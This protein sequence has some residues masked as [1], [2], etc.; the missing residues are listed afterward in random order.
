MKE[1]SISL[2]TFRRRSQKILFSD[3]SEKFNKSKSM[4]KFN[5]S[6]LE[7]RIQ[8]KLKGIRLVSEK[9]KDQQEYDL[10]LPLIKT[11]VKE[12]INKLLSPPKKEINRFTMKPVDP[13]GVINVGEGE[14]NLNLIHPK[15][16]IRDY[17]ERDIFNEDIKD[18]DDF[19]EAIEKRL[20]KIFFY[21]LLFM[22]SLILFFFKFYTLLFFTKF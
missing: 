7:I 6:N 1:S 16:F 19:Y 11:E 13:N 14:Y 15:K 3:E 21:F 9:V 4:I 22:S 10:G 18:K 2:N 20:S 5:S 12:R 8:E 17:L